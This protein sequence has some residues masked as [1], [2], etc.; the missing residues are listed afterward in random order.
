MYRREREVVGRDL[1]EVF[2]RLGA[3]LQH[4]TLPA[5]EPMGVEGQKDLFIRRVEESSGIAFPPTIQKPAFSQQ[6][7]MQRLSECQGSVRSAVASTTSLVW[8]HQPEG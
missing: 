6:I 7:S 4:L 1:G 3:E 2:E 8:W 5:S